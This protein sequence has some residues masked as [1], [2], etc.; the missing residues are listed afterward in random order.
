MPSPPPDTVDILSIL[1]LPWHHQL[2]TARMASCLTGKHFSLFLRP[3][4]CHSLFRV[5]FFPLL[6]SH[7]HITQFP[8]LLPIASYLSSAL[9]FVTNFLLLLHC[10]AFCTSLPHIG[11]TCHYYLLFTQRFTRTSVLLS[12]FFFFFFFIN[13]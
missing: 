12:L 1:K 2:S 7:F 4:G 6:L 8:P 10:S 13:L 5:N 11:C 9:L 3:S